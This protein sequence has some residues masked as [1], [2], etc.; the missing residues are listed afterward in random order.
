MIGEFDGM[1]AGDDHLTGAVLARATRLKIISK[2]GIGTDAIDL[3]AAARLGIRSRTRPRCSATMSPTSP[4]AISC[5]WPDS[6]T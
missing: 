3:E 5:C 4:P 2:W 1:I 6:C